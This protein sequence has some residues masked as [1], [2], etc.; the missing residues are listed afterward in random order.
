MVSQIGLAAKY[1]AGER[2]LELQVRLS[3][4]ARKVA[5]LKIKDRK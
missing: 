2:P 3:S 4:F 5:L 1:T